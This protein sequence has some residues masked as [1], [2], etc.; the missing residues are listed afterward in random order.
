MSSHFDWQR[1]VLADK[2]LQSG[3]KLVILVIGVRLNKKTQAAFPSY[4]TIA[5]EASMSRRSVVS[6]VELAVEAG[7]LRKE[8]RR[9]SEK[10]NYSNIYR[11]SF[12]NSDIE[13]E[14]PSEII[15]S[16][17]VQPL[18]HPSAT[19]APPS[20]T[21]APPLVQPLHPNTEV[22]TPKLTEK[23]KNP[24]SRA[25][26][27]E[28]T[29]AEYRAEFDANGQAII[30]ED[31]PIY[32]TA[33]QMGLP[34]DYIAIAWAAFVAK[35]VTSEKKYK[36]WRATFRNAVANDWLKV[37]NINRDGE[38]FLTTTGKMIEKAMQHGN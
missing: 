30:S 32:S 7:W 20:A 29:F 9:K 15:A 21:I 31:D 34:D 14:E 18:H 13:I 26:K 12:P 35:Y 5:E 22:L 3:T 1:A 2:S 19:I 6:H 11:L 33:E 38:Y 37:W 10:E 16:P 25:K 17:L 28:K 36:D 27:I 23:K 8:V 24:V 4:N